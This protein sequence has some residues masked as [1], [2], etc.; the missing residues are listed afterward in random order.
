[1][2]RVLLFLVAALLFTTGGARGAEDPLLKLALPAG[3]QAQSFV[4]EYQ[5]FYEMLITGD[6]EM[7]LVIETTELRVPMYEAPYGPERDVNVTAI[8]EDSYDRYTTS[9]ETLTFHG[10]AFCRKTRKTAIEGTL[11]EFCPPEARPPV[12]A[13]AENAA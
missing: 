5:D 4:A 9:T 10:P 8:R 7:E 3:V 13:P 6:V 12:T 1:M 11:G 2:R